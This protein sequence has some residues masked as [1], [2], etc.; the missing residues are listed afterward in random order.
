[1]RTIASLLLASTL[2]VA[3]SCSDDSGDRCVDEFGNEL[4]DSDGYTP[5]AESQLCSALLDATSTSS[6]ETSTTEVSTTVVTTTEA[7][8]TVAAATTPATTKPKST[9]APVTAP[10][11]TDQ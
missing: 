7:P 10:A 9:T 11:T 6:P 8:T 5:A 1:M 3:I 4:K 2:V